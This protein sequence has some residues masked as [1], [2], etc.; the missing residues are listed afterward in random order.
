MWETQSNQ[1]IWAIKMFTIFFHINMRKFTV[2]NK[3]AYIYEIY[4]DIHRSRRKRCSCWISAFIFFNFQ[5]KISFFIFLTWLIPCFLTNIFS[6]YL[7][8]LVI[9]STQTLHTAHSASIY[10]KK[11]C[12]SSNYKISIKLKFFSNMKHAVNRSD[13]LN[14]RYELAVL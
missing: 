4:F 12:F 13:S 5:W 9:L 7:P 2:C 8:C 10:L 6:V 11:K 3:N 1:T 14:I